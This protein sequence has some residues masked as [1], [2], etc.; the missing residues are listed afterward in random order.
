MDNYF[1]LETVADILLKS[2]FTIESL[3]KSGK[4]ISELD[5]SKYNKPYSLKQLLI[6]DEFRYL[7]SS[8]WDLEEKN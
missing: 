2:K 1:S 3:Q 4:L 7:I 8:K 5:P 6:F